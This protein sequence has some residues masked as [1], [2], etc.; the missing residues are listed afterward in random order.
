[1]SKARHSLAL[2]HTLFIFL[3]SVN[4]ACS[5]VLNVWLSEATTKAWSKT[6][7]KFVYKFEQTG[8]STPVFLAE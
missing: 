6:I 8:A 5:V 2:F 4:P 7:L 3:E 1:M